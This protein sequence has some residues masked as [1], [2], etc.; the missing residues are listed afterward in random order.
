MACLAPVSIA[1]SNL[2]SKPAK[3]HREVYVAL[4]DS[5]SRGAQPN[6]SGQTVLTHQGYADDIYA[7]EKKEV[8]DLTLE[9]LGCLGE[10]TST[11]IRGGICKYS[12][13]SQLKAAL[14]FLRMH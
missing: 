6:T 1:A 2:A 9:D 4:G 5:L 14:A 8:G 13:G 11:M 3:K 12:G 7:A 10:T